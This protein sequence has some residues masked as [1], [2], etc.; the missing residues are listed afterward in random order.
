MLNEG[1]KAPRF[2]LKN[3]N[4]ETV[5]LSDFKGKNVVLY[6]YPK[7]DTPGCTTEACDFRDEH[8]K[9]SKAGAMVLGVSPDDEK[10]HTK[11]IAKHSL[12][13]SLLV[14]ADHAVA[15]KFGAWGEKQLYGKTYMGVIRS[16]F[17]IGANGKLAK[18]WPKVKVAGHAAEVLE[19]VKSVK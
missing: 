17:L 12:P 6:F 19:A 8:S 15:E 16:T 10:R 11:F 18:V 3:Q 4:G 2:S 14:D 1:D 5:K 13:F 9:I 7:D